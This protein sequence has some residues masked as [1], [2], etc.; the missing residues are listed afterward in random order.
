ME[1]TGDMADHSTRKKIEQSE[2]NSGLFFPSPCDSIESNNLRIV[3]EI[4]L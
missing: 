4:F 3:V 1:E 2:I